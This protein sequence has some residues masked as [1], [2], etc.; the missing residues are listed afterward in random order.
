MT[1][2]KAH[3]LKKYADTELVALTHTG[4]LHASRQI[5]GRS[6][7]LCDSQSHRLGAASR[8]HFIIARPGTWDEITCSK[9]RKIVGLD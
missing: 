7:V 4:M 2:T 8:Y 3:P 9:C 6:C 1:T 5:Q